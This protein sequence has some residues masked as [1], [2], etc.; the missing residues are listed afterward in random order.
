MRTTKRSPRPTSDDI[1]RLVDRWKLYADDAERKELLLLEQNPDELEDSFRCDLAF[2]TG[3]LRGIMGPGT[4][5]MNVRTIGKATQGLANWLNARFDHPSVVIARDTRAL[6]E[7]FMRVVAG[8]LAANGIVAHVHSE[9]SPT[10]TLSFAVREL[11]CSAGICITASHNPAE[12]NGYK[13]YGET[14]C[15]ITTAAASQIQKAIDGVDPFDDV[16]MMP[17]EKALE[18]GMV[19]RIDAGIHASYLDAVISLSHGIDCSSL[20]VAYTPLNGT[21]AA[22]V[23]EI[24]KAIGVKRFELEPIQTLS[25]SSFSTCKRPNPE[26]RE[27]LTRGLDLAKRMQADLLLATD[28]D[29]DRLGVAVKHGEDYTLLTGN[30]VGILLIDHLCSIAQ[31]R[32]ERLDDRVVATTIVSSP[33]ADAL[34]KDYGFELIRTLTGFKFIGEL[35]DRLEEDGRGSAFLFGFEESYGFLAGTHARDKD[36]MAATLLV[37][38]AAARHRSKGLDLV[39]ALDCLYAR[40]GRCRSKLISISYPGAKGSLRMHEIMDSLRT[41]PPA[42]IAGTPVTKVNDYKSGA[43]PPPTINVP[44]NDGVAKPLPPSDVLELDLGDNESIFIR[45]SGTEPK[46]KAYINAFGLDEDQVR[47]RIGSLSEGVSRLMGRPLRQECFLSE[48]SAPLRTL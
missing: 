43:T 47:T 42:S 41:D 1:L 19:R 17:F 40:Y 23:P 37:C 5:R 29:A 7:Q 33:M 28:P 22:F 6:G 20:A 27:A 45:P 48:E 25:D 15:Q 18:Q 10:P 31:S 16:Q 2:G 3:G 11:G 9:P 14:G 4:N 8:V 46:V 32:G 44:E 30:E 13:V 35:I 21:G 12:Y 26:E 24:L 34:A 39:E 36:A 38:E